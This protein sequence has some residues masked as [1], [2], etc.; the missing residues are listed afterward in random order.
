MKKIS[1]IKAISLLCAAVTVALCV[2]ACAQNENK[3]IDYDGDGMVATVIEVHD[4][5]LLVAPAEGSPEARSSDRF[6]VPNYF[7]KK[8]K[9]GDTVIIEHDGMIQETYPASF[10]RI[11]SMTLVGD[12]GINENVCID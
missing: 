1:I 4:S 3:E 10:H 5:Y 9:K 6:S 8:V 7:A 11:F 2:A 12:D